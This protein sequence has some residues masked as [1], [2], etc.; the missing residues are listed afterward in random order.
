MSFDMKKNGSAL[1]RMAPPGTLVLMEGREEFNRVLAAAVEVMLTDGTIEGLVRR[2][3]TDFPALHSE[4]SGAVAQAVEKLI[5]RQVAPRRPAAYLAASA[6]NVLKRQMRRRA[7]TV[8]LDALGEDDGEGSW[9]PEDSEWS[10]EEQALLRET[11]DELCGQVK[12]W[13]TENVRVVTLLYLEA[14]FNC[15]PLPSDIAAEIASEILGEEVDPS[16]VRTW[17]SRGFKRLR[18]YVNSIETAEQR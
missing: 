9:E 15:E 17:K 5:R 2:L 10:V 3:Q 8:S 13:E 18:E 11:Y 14:A 12:T 7:R 16:F 6:F 4:A 1:S